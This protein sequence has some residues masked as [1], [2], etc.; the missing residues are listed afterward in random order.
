LVLAIFFI[1]SIG[2][3]LSGIR[4]EAMILLAIAMILYYT[5]CYRDKKNRSSLIW[6]VLAFLVFVIFRAEYLALFLPAYI[7]WL[8]TFNGKRRPM[9]IY[10]GVYGFCILIFLLSLW[11][12]PEKN[13]ATPMVRSQQNFITLH[14]NTRLPLDS[15]Q[16]N[17]FGVVKVFPQAFA[18][19]FLRPWITE[20]KGALQI[21]GSL[22][23]MASWILLLLCLFF[24][25][26]DRW[27]ILG[28]P[29]IQ[30]FIY[31]GLTQI[32]IIGFL[33][34]FPGAIIRYKSIPELLL[35]LSLGLS[36]D[37]R[38]LYSRKL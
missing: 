26:A 24:R 34:P 17:I 9:T 25:S 6:I 7:C 4:A 33:V 28:H 19:S 8:I 3:W 21:F 29:L 18:N 37:W 35:V 5:R 10:P 36:I 12:S 23:I 22:E 38:R 2:F 32:L 30:L 13:L 20:A 1:P 11:I 14:G 27:K 16:A 15:L 31:Y